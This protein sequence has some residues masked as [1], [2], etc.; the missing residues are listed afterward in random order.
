MRCFLIGFAGFFVAALVTVVAMASYA[1]YS[2]RASLGE[3]MTSVAPLRNQVA[4]SLANQPGLPIRATTEIPNVDYLKVT[5]D[6]TIVFRSAKHG[7]M[8]VFEPSV[9]GGAVSWR[10]IGSPGKTIPADCR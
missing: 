3:T 5:N 1:D 8:I 2:E 6:G 10:C 7:Q 9:K 4:E